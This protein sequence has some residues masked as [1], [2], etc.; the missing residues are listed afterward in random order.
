[1]KWK[2][3]PSAADFSFMG[4]PPRPVRRAWWMR[5]LLGEEKDP[6]DLGSTIATFLFFSLGLVVVLVDLCFA[7]FRS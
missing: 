5:L 7:V 4:P 3:R 6:I 2:R 1:M